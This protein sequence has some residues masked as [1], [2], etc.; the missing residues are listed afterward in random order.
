MVGAKFERIQRIE[1]RIGC[2]PFV[3][4]HFSL[5]NPFHF[6]VTSVGMPKG[7]S[8]ARNVAPQVQIPIYKAGSLKDFGYAARLTAL[9]RHTALKRA[10]QLYGKDSVIH[11][12]DAV[13]TFSKNKPDLRTIYESDINYVQHVPTNSG[14]IRHRG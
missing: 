3:R 2:V 8:R 10:I 7:R 12:L 4:L 14:V 1:Q 5:N 13:R 9:A 6:I 11:K